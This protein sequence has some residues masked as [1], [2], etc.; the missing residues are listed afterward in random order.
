LKY[1]TIKFSR[2]EL[3][4]LNCK[5]YGFECDFVVEGDLEKVIEQFGLHT[6][7]VHGIDYSKEAL[8]QIIMRKTRWS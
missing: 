3:A 2:K 8:M 4:K 6:E 1:I 7:E 5:D